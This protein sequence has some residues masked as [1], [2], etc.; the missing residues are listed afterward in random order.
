MKQ[1]SDI[2][3]R[4]RVLATGQGPLV[5]VPIVGRDRDGVLGDVSA[6]VGDGADLIEWR[7]DYFEN[8]AEAKATLDLLVDI[9]QSAQETPL[10]FTLRSEREGGEPVEMTDEGTASLCVEVCRSELVD[11]V[12]F[13]MT[14]PEEQIRTVL[15]AAQEH[16]TR[17]VLSYHNF[18]E[19][20]VL[21]ELFGK[22]ARAE[23]LGGDVAKVAVMPQSLDDV[24][25]LL[26]AT[27]QASRDVDMPL[28]SISMGELGAFT[29]AIGWYFGSA[30]TFAAGRQR[31][32][33]GQLDVQAVK[34]VVALLGLHQSG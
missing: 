26:Q 10:I 16:G 28:I 11:F 3:A 2:V 15:A 12:D 18:E 6:A 29:R 27:L 8:V 7:A 23:A 9:R 31:S 1:A 22:F 24:L 25:V 32:A 33:P 30:V 34:D 14:A 13:E 20:P 19:T 4:G 5:C 17:T 21:E